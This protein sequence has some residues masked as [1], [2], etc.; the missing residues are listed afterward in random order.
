VSHDHGDEAA[1][2]SADLVPPIPAMPSVPRSELYP[3]TPYLLADSTLRYNLGWQDHRKPGPSFVV[4]RNSRLGAIRIVE[5]FPLTEQGWTGAWR[6]LSGRD[7]RAAVALAA[8]LAK[9]EAGRREADALAALDGESLCCL[10]RVTFNGG[11]GAVPLAKGKPYDVRFLADRIMVSAPRSGNAIVEV[12][13]QDVETV[14]VSGTN[15]SRSPGELTA[16]IAAFGLLGA[17][18]GFLVLGLLGLF[19]GAVIF[20]LVAAMVG[21]ASTKIET[22]VRIRAADAELYFVDTQKRQDALR[23]ALSEPL[24]AIGKAHAGQDEPAQPTPES[25]SDRLSKLAALLQQ[26]L[27]TRDEFEHLKA[28][29]IAES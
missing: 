29:L 28:K 2:V 15:P 21:A 11:S 26:G 25:I 18:L 8:Q 3:G 9:R 27:I 17:L 23:V 7:A 5:R 12:P 4:T 1:Q 19:L 16:L 14:E 13:Y 20:G 22:V 24:R 10:W 6:T